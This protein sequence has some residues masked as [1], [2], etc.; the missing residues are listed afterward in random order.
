MPSSLNKHG[1]CARKAACMYN[2][3][4]LTLES[5]NT[6]VHSGIVIPV[7]SCPTDNVIVFSYFSIAAFTLS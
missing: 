4:D 3:G 1:F 2:A 6:A 7:V 5:I